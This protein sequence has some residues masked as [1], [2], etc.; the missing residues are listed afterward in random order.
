MSPNVFDAAAVLLVLAA[1]FGFFNHHLL[2]LP[3]SIGLMLSGLVASVGVLAIDKAFPLFELGQGVRTAISSIDF[4]KSLMH[5]M[6]S[7]L[8]FAGA[9][10]V[11]LEDLLEKRV[12]SLR[13]RRS[14]F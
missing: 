2:R 10:H 9:L 11:N 12:P 14:A 3:F 5:G 4:P 1:L 7:F 8:L 13:S 6:L